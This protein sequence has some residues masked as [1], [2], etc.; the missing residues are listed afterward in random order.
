MKNIII[1]AKLFLLGLVGSTAVG[2]QAAEQQAKILDRPLIPTGLGITMQHG[3]EYY[4]GQFSIDNAAIYRTAEDLIYIDAARR[5][6]FKFL[7]ERR[8]SGR[9]FARQLV[10][11]MKINNEKVA[12]KANLANI[13]L[14]K[15]FFKKSF[16]KGDLLR[17][18]YHTDFGTRVFL[19]NRRLGEISG[20]SSTKKEFFR[21]IINIWLGERPPSKKFRD[22]LLG[23][24]DDAYA[25]T[26]QKRFNE[27]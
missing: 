19:N 24:N 4:I 16:K 13:K 2:I 18:D 27:L 14:F 25:I 8:T 21:L 12:L 6:E 11:G 22:G 10:E 23:Q 7:S 17:I 9:T 20:D 15:S 5:M 1:I 3:K 26:L